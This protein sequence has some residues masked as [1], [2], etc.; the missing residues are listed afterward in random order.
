MELDAAGG[1]PAG[2]AD[3]PA[4]P[5]VK[6]QEIPDSGIK[7]GWTT[8]DDAGK[9]ASFYS[10]SLAAQGWAT[11]RVD[12]DDGSL[13]FGDKGARS[14]TIGIGSG[15]GKTTIDLLLVLDALSRPAIPGADASRP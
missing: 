8:S 6:S 10:D 13:V 11:R 12:G 2:R 15:P 14:L 7:V 5:V 9:V 3:L 4:A 1:L